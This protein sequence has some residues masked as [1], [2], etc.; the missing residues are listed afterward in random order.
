MTTSSLKIKNDI[1]QHLETLC[2]GLYKREKEISAL[3]LSVLS[4]HNA[5]L[6]GKPGVAKS[7]VAHRVLSALPQ[8]SF[9]LQLSAYTEI[10]ELFGPLNLTQFREKDRRVRMTAGYLPSAR[11][12]FLDE[13]FKAQSS[14]LNSLLLLLN[15]RTYIEEGVPKLT[16][17][18]AVIAA[19]NERPDDDATALADRMC[20]YIDV[21]ATPEGEVE[22]LLRFVNDPSTPKGVLPEPLFEMKHIAKIKFQIESVVQENLS[23]IIGL[24]KAF[25]ELLSKHIGSQ[26]LYNDAKLSDRAMVQCV[27][28]LAASCVLRS[29]SVVYTTDAWF[30]EYMAR[31]EAYTDAYRAATV[32]LLQMGTS[33]QQLR[34][35]LISA[36]ANSGSILKI[37]AEIKNLPYHWQTEI[38]QLVE[39]KLN[40]K[41]NEK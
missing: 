3:L 14:T 30:L 25:N 10:E 18:E 13:I 27:T 35:T 22:S 9:T 8:P 36:S 6:I 37:Q 38:Q 29:D 19:S 33:L 17:L 1:P 2:K 16:E 24:I 23:K 39:S 4:G 21:P 32:E 41:Q 15:E 5:V 31:S 7:L 11:Y 28:L 20:M 26:A 40:Q 34:Q 12:A